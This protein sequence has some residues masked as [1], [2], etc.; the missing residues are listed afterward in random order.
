MDVNRAAGA[1]EGND[2]L[3]EL[4]S[5]GD[6]GSER[7]A[8]DD[9]L[10]ERGWSNVGRFLE[11]GFAEEA[12]DGVMEIGWENVFEIGTNRLEDLG[13]SGVGVVQSA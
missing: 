3:G 5:E 12:G 2:G 4:D 9:A 13:V 11:V 7:C 8:P 1:R 6:D 10:N